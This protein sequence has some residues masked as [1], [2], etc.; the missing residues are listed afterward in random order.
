MSQVL[1]DLVLGSAPLTV[2]TDLHLREAQP[3]EILA[4]AQQVDAVDSDRILLILGD[5]FDAWTG[6]ESVGADAFAPLRSTLRGRAAAGAR[7]ILLRGNRDVLMEPR[8]AEA[9]GLELADR[10]LWEPPR[11]RQEGAPA[12]A[13]ILFSHGDEYCLND[14]PYQ[15]LRRTLRRAWVRA[16]LRALPARL[17]IAMGRR[18]RRHSQGAVARKPLDV[19]SLE[20][21]A[22]AAALAR[23]GART[24]IIGHLHAAAEHDLGSGGRL[25]VLP[26]WEPGQAPWTS[27]TA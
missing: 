19:L 15:K 25:Q 22:A 17:R 1:P 26:A 27:P 12:P 7:T 6:P 4:F 11:G 18:M 21:P 8:Q 14:A 3:D 16:V 23:V 13:A 10:V 9:L 24:A 5:L 2:W 20:L